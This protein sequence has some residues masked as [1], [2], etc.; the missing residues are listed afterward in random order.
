MHDMLRQ[1]NISFNEFLLE[2]TFLQREIKYINLIY[3][4]TYEVTLQHTL[5]SMLI[6]KFKESYFIYYDF[7][8]SYNIYIM[9][10]V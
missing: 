8:L 2:I 1:T 10:A 4:R 9:F 3:S 6:R 5:H 7:V